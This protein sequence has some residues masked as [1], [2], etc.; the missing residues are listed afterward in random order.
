[1][2]RRNHMFKEHLESFNFLGRTTYLVFKVVNDF[3]RAN[4]TGQNRCTI[5]QAF[6]FI[7]DNQ[8]VTPEIRRS[9]MIE[10]R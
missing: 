10:T 7:R 9:L 6:N 3:I 1:M 2:L 5:G 4:V 8:E